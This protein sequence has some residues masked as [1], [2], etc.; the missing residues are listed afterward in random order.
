M[1]VIEWFVIVTKGMIIVGLIDGYR[2][3]EGGRV[4][5]EVEGGGGGIE[6]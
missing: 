5:V 2:S 3:I 6:K 4:V 1:R